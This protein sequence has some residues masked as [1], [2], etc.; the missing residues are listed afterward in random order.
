MDFDQL[1]VLVVEPSRMQRKVITTALR[2]IGV[3]DIEEF[4]SGTTALQRMQLITPDI[5]LSSMHLPDMT[6]TEL[7][8]EM[9]ASATLQ[10]ITFL[11]VS[12]ET[13]FRYLEPIRQSGAIAILPK[14][15][16]EPDLQRALTSTLDY[17]DSAQQDDA[18]QFEFLRVLIADDSRLSRKYVRQILESIGIN[19][20]VE[21]D[22]GAAALAAINTGEFDF[23]ISDYNMPEIDGKE[24]IE[25][26][27]TNDALHSL[28]IV[29]ITSEQSP[30]R[31]AAI[32][33]A[34]VSAI[35]NKPLEYG[36]M[37]GLLRHLL[38]EIV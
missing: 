35:C 3:S 5:V 20:I 37:R 2:K 12:S 16:T 32:Q 14:P 15:F 34:G 31:L 27:R 30:A 8:T 38:K 21:V 11:L 33:N 10:D 25:H 4:E 18:E 13:H 22:N 24:L 9:R 29:M 17:I 26:V 19:D 28:P 36:S 1:L 7:V 23:V 6:G